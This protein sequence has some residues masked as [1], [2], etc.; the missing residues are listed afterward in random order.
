[1]VI[2]PDGD[3][4]AVEILGEDRP[5][6]RDRWQALT[7]RARVT[8][9]AATCLVVLSALLGYALANRP[10]P[11]P[12]DPADA[13]GVSIAQVRMPVDGSPYFGITFRVEAT[14][15]VTVVAAY[16]GYDN[17]VLYVSPVPGRRLYPGHV[18]TLTAQAV[19]CTCRTPHASRGTPLLYLSVRN[20]RGDRRIRVV[21]TATQF[22]RLE[23]ALRLSCGT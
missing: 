3:D 1:M 18:S 7:R 10:P 6:L 15:A 20:A 21:P 16:E 22:D 17:L 9:T 23:Q 2:P 13:T 12:P 4:R 5:L 11:A 19:V 8:I 14:S